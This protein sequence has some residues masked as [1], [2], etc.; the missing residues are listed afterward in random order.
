MYDDRLYHRHVNP[1]LNAA[2]RSH[3]DP[4]TGPGEVGGHVAA[5]EPMR[6]SSETPQQ[7]YG[8]EYTVNVNLTLV[9]LDR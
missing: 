7:S 2:S 5:L 4:H 1:T 9:G 3:G 8:N 6:T